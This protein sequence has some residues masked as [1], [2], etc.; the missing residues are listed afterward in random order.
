MK[1]KLVKLLGIL[2]LTS[3][4]LIGM[5]SYIYAATITI[6]DNIKETDEEYIKYAK[7]I[8]EKSLSYESE[9]QEQGIQLKIKCVYTIN[10]IQREREDNTNFKYEGILKTYIDDEL[11]DESY[12]LD[13]V[14]IAKKNEYRGTTKASLEDISFE[15]KGNDAC[16]KGKIRATEVRIGKEYAL[17][18]NPSIKLVD[19]S[20]KE[21]DATV[22]KNKA[23]LYEFNLKINNLRKLNGYRIC[24]ETSNS[25]NK[26]PLKKIAVKTNN[27]GQKI[28]T[29]DEINL[30][31]ENAVQCIILRLKDKNSNAILGDVNGDKKVNTLDAI[32]ILQYVAKKIA[33]T[34][35]Q[36]N[37]ADINGDKSVAAMDA[38]KILQY[39]AKKIP[40]L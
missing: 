17:E 5:N 15:G 33:L 29:N 30:E 13:S 3:I 2:V 24:V 35:E 14:I 26:S 23:G 34:E 28:L 9:V 39:V 25:N 12:D 6:P 31:V 19:S 20:G 40:T 16:I 21:Y 32:K 27:N 4:I 36:M 38:V 18:K 11:F 1:N 22:T 8:L 10:S 7:N 37:I